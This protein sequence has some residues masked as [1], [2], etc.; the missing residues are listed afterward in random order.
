MICSEN[1]S[2]KESNDKF[3]RMT[4]E[5]NMSDLKGD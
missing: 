3:T 5:K 1:V 4:Y 2:S